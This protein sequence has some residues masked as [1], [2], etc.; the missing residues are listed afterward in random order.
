MAE[1][2]PDVLVDSTAWVDLNTATGI[3][4]GTP[5]NIVNKSVTWC[6]LYESSTTPSLSVDGGDL[7]SSYDKN[8]A[9]ANTKSGS[10]TIWALSTIEGRTLKL[11][12]KEI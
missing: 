7:I 3:A 2:L 8:Y 4:V 9:S 6:K 5:M 12:I 10:L 11:A 1:T